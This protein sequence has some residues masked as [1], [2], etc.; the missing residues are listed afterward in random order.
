MVVHF[1][2]LMLAELDDFEAEVVLPMKAEGVVDIL[3][4]M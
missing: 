2:L 4:E 1:V 3:E